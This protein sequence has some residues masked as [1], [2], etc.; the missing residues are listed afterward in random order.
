MKYLPRTIILTNCLYE[1]KSPV[2]TGQGP[3]EQQTLTP[4]RTLATT[5]NPSAVLFPFP[6]LL[7]RSVWPIASNTGGGYAP[8]T[9]HRKQHWP[10]EGRDIYPHNASDTTPTTPST[11]SKGINNYPLPSPLPSALSFFSGAYLVTLLNVRLFIAILGSTYTSLDVGK[12]Y[13]GGIL[14]GNPDRSL[15]SFPPCYSQTPLLTNYTPLLQF[16]WTWYFYIFALWFLQQ[17]L[18]RGGSLG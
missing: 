17:Q 13:R 16:S 5:P 10:I 8:L 18:G 11:V 14:G 2:T 6:Y 15:K 1:G 7:L 4:I 12:L 9:N 3:F